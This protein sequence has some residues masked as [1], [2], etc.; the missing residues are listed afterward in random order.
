M[1]RRKLTETKATGQPRS[2]TS[3]APLRSVASIM[4]EYRGVDMDTRI[5][6]FLTYR[7]LCKE[8]VEIEVEGDC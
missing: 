1:K 7:D 8:F 6:L 4:D 3:D 5:H 2:L